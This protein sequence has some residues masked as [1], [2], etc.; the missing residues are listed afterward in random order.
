MNI[1]ILG[2]GFGAY[3]A[4]L[5]SHMTEV[6]EIYV[7]G[8]KPE[9]LQKLQEKFGVHTVT[10][11]EEILQN[12]GITLIDLCLP[13]ALHKEYSIRALKQG[14]HVFCETPVAYTL[15]DAY[16]MLEAKQTYG[17]HLMVDLFIRFEYAYEL[18]ASYVKDHRYGAL[19]K[20]QIQRNTAPI[21][22]D[23]GP[24]KIVMDLM[25]HDI[26]YVTSLLGPTTNIQTT[27]VPG[28]EGQCAVSA[29]C[30]YEHAYA[31][32]NASS[33]MQYGFPFVVSFEAIF[34]NAVVRYHEDGYETQ[35][36]TRFQLFTDK[37]QENLPL[38]AINCYEKSLQYVLHAI[39]AQETPIIDIKEAIQSLEMAT[40]IRE[41]LAR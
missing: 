37:K 26:D 35:V 34:E 4:E 20:I 36:D 16:A 23:L 6:D 9:K 15:D 3:H 13:T 40:R 28:K 30:T 22:G 27:L 29:L 2:T 18:L 21:W 31:E 7:F 17:K 8:R 41:S 19:R 25:S 10:D 14:K 1:G 38:P 33:M 39:H 11:P 24:D 32:I 5:Y 12:D